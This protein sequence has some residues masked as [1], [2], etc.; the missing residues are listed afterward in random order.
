MLCKTGFKFSPKINDTIDLKN[1]DRTETDALADRGLT[2][3]ATQSK[4]IEHL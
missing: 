1:R 4:T 2:D 3:L